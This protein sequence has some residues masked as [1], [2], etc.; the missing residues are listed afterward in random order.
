M[1]PEPGTRSRATPVPVHACNLLDLFTHTAGRFPDRLAVQDAATSLDYKQLDELADRWSAALANSGLRS[2]DAIVLFMPRCTALVAALYSIV[3]LQGVLVPVSD[4]M[5]A[6]RLEFIVKDA[7]ARAVLVTGKQAAALPRA[8]ADATVIDVESLAAPPQPA[9]EP[10][11]RQ[12][13]A[14]IVYT[15]GTTGYPKGVCTSHASITARYR[16]WNSLFG[17]D[18]APLRILQIAKA[19][20][21]VFIGD[22]VKSMGS[23]AALIIC[24]DMVVVNPAELYRWLVEERIDYVDI[25]PAVLRNLIEYMTERGLDLASLSIVNCGAD[26]WTKAEYLS[27]RAILKVKRLFNGYGVSECS[28]ESIMFEDD[29][30]ILANKTTLPIGRPLDSDHVLIVDEQLRPVGSDTVGQLCLGGPCVSL[31]YLNLPE[32]NREVFVTLPYNGTDERFYLTGDLATRDSGGIIEFIGRIDSQIKINGNRVELHEIERVLE[33]H[34]DVKQAVAYYDAQDTALYA[35]VVPM[36]PARFDSNQLGK[37]IEAH[38]PRYM[39]PRRIVPIERAILNQNHK[40]DRKAVFMASTIKSNR[41]RKKQSNDLYKC[42]SVEQLLAN[43]H[44]R[45]IDIKLLIDEFIKPSMR[46]SILVGGSLAEQTAS[47]VSDLDLLILLDDARAF[48]RQK[49]DLFGHRV[50]YLPSPDE[51]E[52]IA[53]IFISGLEIECQFLVNDKLTVSTAPD[54]TDY[55]LARQSRLAENNK[56]LC[57]LASPWV[58]RDDGLL[59]P[60]R[61]CYELDKIRLKRTIEEFVAATK[62]LEDMAAAVGGDPYHLGVMGSYIAAHMTLALLAG[63]GYISKSA[64]WMKKVAHLL[65][66]CPHELAELLTRGRQLAIPGLRVTAT[67]QKALFDDTL[68]FCVAAH[69]H[70]SRD[71]QLAALLDALIVDFDIVL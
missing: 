31:G 44:A 26:L 59:A 67:E 10:R 34:P 61:Q 24:P 12:E 6:A 45:D 53:S 21:D 18:R 47:A 11:D 2:G 56:F 70:L 65:E 42:R 54:H 30:T 14:Y 71:Q 23:G 25:V 8:I 40:V 7:R 3:K 58:V 39:W 20:F 9:L 19:G 49:T 1:S 5:P 50:N 64:K 66:D 16:D 68:Q 33:R 28:V 60:W 62:N 35:F 15:S 43:L 29:G 57:R 36:A 48:K 22:V 63:Q 27:F 4:D 32:R 46:R 55:K 17:L 13:L 69:R 41:N 37:S 52:I 51:H 38:L